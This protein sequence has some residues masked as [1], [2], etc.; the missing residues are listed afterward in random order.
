VTRLGKLLDPFADSLTFVTAFACFVTDGYMALWMFWLILLR[1][2]SMHFFLRPY[3]QM[4]GV[5]MAAKRA[6]KFKTVMQSIV[7]LVLLA[8]LVF[9]GEG[10]PV[11]PAAVYSQITLAFNGLFLALT[12]I[13]LGSMV[14]YLRE[15]FRVTVQ[16]ARA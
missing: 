16:E 1:E 12:V 13:S 15:L 10:Q 7:S 14:S 4:R 11:F 9:K 8:F 3:F 2:V 6:G 5:V